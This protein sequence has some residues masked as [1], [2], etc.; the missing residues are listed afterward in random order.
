ML[1][2]LGSMEMFIIVSF[3]FALF[4]IVP[5][6]L[7]T[8]AFRKSK[9][10]EVKDITPYHLMEPE[11]RLLML[12]GLRAK[13]LISEEEFDKKRKNILREL[14]GEQDEE[15]K[16]SSPPPLPEDNPLQP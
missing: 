16:E 6:I 11:E 15:E 7:I 10:N 2:S 4:I 12:Q 3:I 5:L 14:D 1:G 8:I 13:E 9:K